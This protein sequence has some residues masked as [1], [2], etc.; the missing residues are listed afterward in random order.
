MVEMLIFEGRGVVAAA[1]LFC[2]IVH[3]CTPLILGIDPCEEGIL[4]YEDSPPD[5]LYAGI[6]AVFLGMKNEMPKA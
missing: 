3:L 2:G 5:A 4:I 1:F 6:E